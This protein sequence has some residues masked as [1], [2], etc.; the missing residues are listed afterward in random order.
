MSE[1]V[2]FHRSA[3]EKLAALPVGERVAIQRAREKLVALGDRLPF[4]HQS[5]VA[6]A[7]R[8][9]ELRPRAGRSRWR[10]LYS[11]TSG[12][13]VVLAIAP[14]AQVDRAG[15]DRAV[16]RAVR[17]LADIEEGINGKDKDHRRRRSPPA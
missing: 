16:G 3:Y 17:R 13:Y 8:L 11:R 6:G 4:P 15:F 12:G 1:R 7:T 2:D 5:A 9:R 10:A 14:E